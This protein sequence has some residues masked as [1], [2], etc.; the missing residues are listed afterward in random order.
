MPVIPKSRYFQGQSSQPEKFLSGDE[1]SHQAL[2]DPHL[3][4]SSSVF[5]ISQTDRQKGERRALLG[6]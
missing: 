5:A 4:S 2:K 1:T 3:G 6:E